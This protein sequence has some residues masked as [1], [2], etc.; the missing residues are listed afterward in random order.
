VESNKTV[1]VIEEAL[2]EEKPPKVSVCVVAYNQERY[3]A[4]CLQSI[5]DQETDFDFEIIVGDDCSTD[6][7]R[8]IVRGFA[9]KFPDKFRILC[10]SQNIGATLN[11][12]RTHEMAKGEYVAHIDGDDLMLPH[13]LQRQANALEENPKC[14]MVSHDMLIINGQGLLNKRTFKR[15][16]GGVNTLWDLYK[17]LPFFAHS[18]KMVKKEVELK[19]LPAISNGTI[20]IE[21]HV[22]MAEIGDIFHID[23]PLGIYRAGTG[24]SASKKTFVNPLLI[25]GCRRIFEGSIA[26]YPERSL[27]LRKSYSRAM[28]NYAYQSAILKN[29]ED[30][31]RFLMWSRAIYRYSILRSVLSMLPT[32]IVFELIGLRS[33]IRQR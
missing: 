18:S 4:Q 7:T 31:I 33:K 27:D 26:R 10:H 20:D 12:L 19:T 24:I 30:Y 32:R 23:E 2:P 22:A 3:I 21:L 1:A 25:E 9:E 5:V 16:R 28:L 13:K 6:G 8:G 11:Y 14:A 17:T 29:K 15:H